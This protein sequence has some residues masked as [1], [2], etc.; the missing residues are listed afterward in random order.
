M[1]LQKQNV[2]KKERKQRTGLLRA[3]LLAP[4]CMPARPLQMFLGVAAELGWA[5]FMYDFLCLGW[6]DM[7]T[8]LVEGDGRCDLAVAGIGVRDKYWKAGLNFTFPT[9]R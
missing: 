6:D 4:T 5:P 3:L 7:M 8:S 2:R 9:F 1:K